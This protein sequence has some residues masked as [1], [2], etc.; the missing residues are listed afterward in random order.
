MSD[1]FA[2]LRDLGVF[3]P[4]RQQISKWPGY[5]QIHDFTLGHH[6]KMVGR[7]LLGYF[8]QTLRASEDVRKTLLSIRKLEKSQTG[9]VLFLGTGPSLANLSVQQLLY[10]R[11]TGGKI[12]ALNGYMYTSL[13]RKVRPDYYFLGD[14]QYW[15]PSL[16]ENLSF[17]SDLQEYLVESQDE[18]VLAIPAN[19]KLWFEYHNEIMY[20]DHRSLSGLKQKGR[21]DRPWGLSPSVTLIGISYLKFLGFSKI[22]FA[23]LDSNMNVS[24]FVNHLNEL[25]TDYSSH[26][27]YSRASHDLKF[28]QEYLAPNVKNTLHTPI[29]N[30]ADL[31][32]AQA[33]F[34]RDMYWMFGDNCINVG[35]DLSNDSASRACLLGGVRGPDG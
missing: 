12:A 14:P 10:F 23:G 28:N 11:S 25:V 31:Y 27:E 2:R 18:I 15:T 21:P 5:Q 6:L 24:Y 19:R 13:G 9:E 35:N 7:E 30:M 3:L 1:L 4:F 33:I 22:Y 32:Y 8:S 26:Y 16:K 20:W 17:Q 29:R 34:F